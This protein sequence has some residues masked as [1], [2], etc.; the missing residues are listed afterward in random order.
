M[1]T[2][3]AARRLAP[4]ALLYALLIAGALGADY[5]LHAV[6]WAWAGRWFGLAGTFVLLTSFLYS[7]RKRKIVKLGSPKALLDLHETLSWIGALLILIHAGVHFH[8]ALP[9]LATALLLVVAASGFIGKALLREAREH[10]RTKEASLKAAGLPPAEVEE[11]THLDALT[12]E[13]MARWRSI[14]LPMTALLALLALLHIA[15]IG[16]FGGW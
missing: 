5:L 9:W 6:G 16:Y 12:V 1:R 10:L 14:H 4:S 2:S 8:A 13:W 7:L 15:A 3:F 11:R